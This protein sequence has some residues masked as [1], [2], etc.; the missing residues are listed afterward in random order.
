MD[1]QHS[2]LGLAEGRAPWGARRYISRT[3]FLMYPYVFV[4]DPNKRDALGNCS[5]LR[6]PTERGIRQ[7]PPIWGTPNIVVT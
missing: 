3:V 4:E 5:L 7:H 6:V 1:H 2:A